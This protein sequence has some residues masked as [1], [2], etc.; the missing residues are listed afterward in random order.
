MGDEIRGIVEDDLGAVTALLQEGFPH[1][2]EDYWPTAIGHLANRDRTT[3]AERYGYLL[4][5][6][7]LPRGL[8]LAIPSLHDEQGES[9]L[10]VNLSG[11]YVQ[12]EFRR[13]RALP[14]YLRAS[15]RKDVTYTNLTPSAQTIEVITRF[16]FEEWTAGQMLAIDLKLALPTS[17][18][19][20]LLDIEGAGAA[21]LPAGDLALLSDH[22]RLGCL[23]VC[24][25]T[26]D[27]LEPLIFLKRRIKGR[28]P[29]GQ[30]IFCRSEATLI[31]YN[32]AVSRGLW[33]LGYPVMLLDSSASVPRFQ[34]R[35][36]AGKRMR[37][38]KGARPQ[39]FIDHT[40]SE[41]AFFPGVT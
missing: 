25:E 28:L 3:D 38:F 13:G 7:G 40:Y 31:E 26:P 23:A 18:K 27:G 11:W 6:D 2:R 37:Y 41:L 17:R 29:C 1:G 12:P 30:L 4:I 19:A 22:Q 8:I 39:S 32:H 33:R 16:G 21:G 14:L 36:V 10:F 15:R 24:L 9:R 34:G 35:F 5:V 20:R